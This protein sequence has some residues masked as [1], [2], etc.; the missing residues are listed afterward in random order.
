[1]TSVWVQ[2]KNKYNRIR[3][4]LYCPTNWEMCVTAA[5]GQNIT[6]QTITVEKNKQ[7]HYKGKKQNTFGYT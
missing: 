4:F 6:K 2:Q 3:E 5:N 7:Y 1:M